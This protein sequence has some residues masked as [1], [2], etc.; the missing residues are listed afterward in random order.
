ME[1]FRWQSNH[2]QIQHSVAIKAT[3]SWKAFEGG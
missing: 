3:K 2:Q 1:A